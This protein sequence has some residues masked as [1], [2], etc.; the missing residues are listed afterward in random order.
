ML[1]YKKLGLKAGLEIHQQLDTHKL[2]CNCPSFIR[3]DAHNLI[4]KRRL[5]AVV[6]ETGKIDQAALHELQKGKEFIYE[7]YTDTNCLVETDEEP[8]HQL[9]KE[10]LEIA[11][12]LSLLLNAKPVD[13]IQVMRK[14][15]VDGSNTAGFQRS[16]LISNNGYIKT[17]SGEIKI[18]GIYLE[19]DAARKIREDEKTITYRLDRLGIPLIEI[20]TSPDITAPEQAKEVAAYIG[21]ILRST[22][23]VKRGLGTIRQ[24]VNLSIKK[25]VR[26]EIKGVQ[27]LNSIPKVIEKE[28]ERQ[29]DLIKKKSSLK[30]E[31][32]KA[33]PDNTTTFLRPMPG[34]ERLYPE[35]D[36]KTLS[37]TPELLKK[38]KLPELITERAIKLEKEYKLSPEQAKEIIDNEN[39][40]NY[41]KQFKKIEPSFIAHTLIEIPKEIKTR[42]NLSPEKI[43]D[44]DFEFVLNALNSEKIPKS[45]VLEILVEIAKGEKPSLDKYSSV[46]EDNLEKEIKEIVDK[47]KGASINA[48][49]GII[50]G[51]Y[52]GKVDGAKVMEILKKLVK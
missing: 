6:G 14:T 13:E 23:K 11:L 50:M 39:F 19:E 35:T 49:M 33:N 52:H 43:K 12:Q 48:L 51:K 38:I 46:S 28:I 16:A 17:K 18:T 8:P 34:A 25:G 26:V 41:V 45:A 29:L 9:N 32:R 36:L 31:V 15:V 47:N 21:M 1:D 20:S 5:R 40:K 3:E 30:E 4:T 37:I 27:D 42:F 22:G 44:K 2:F 10:A 7:I 24:D